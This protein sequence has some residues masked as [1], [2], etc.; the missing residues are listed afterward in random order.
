ML[1]FDPT[2]TSMR[3]LRAAGRSMSCESDKYPR[4]E[5]AV[6]ACAADISLFDW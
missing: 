4:D 2:G 3:L 1:A 5:Q 6:M